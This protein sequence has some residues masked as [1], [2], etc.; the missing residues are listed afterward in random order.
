VGAGGGP[1]SP[2]VWGG[3]G[4][5]SSLVGGG[6][7][8]CS[9]WVGGGGEPSSSPLV[10]G[11]G[12]GGSSSP[13]VGGGDGP[14]STLVC[15]LSSLRAVAALCRRC[16]VSSRPSLSLSC[17]HL[18]VVL[19]RWIG[20]GELTVRC[21]ENGQRRTT[22]ESSFVVWL[23]RRCRRR[24]TWMSCQNEEGGLGWTDSPIADGDDVV[25]R[26]RQ[27]TPHRRRGVPWAWLM[28]V[29]TWIRLLTWR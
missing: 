8:P 2:L 25:R 12:A 7:G 17:R 3:G 24:G 15:V 23:P 14:S 22:M 13:L 29:V 28:M 6:V 26:H 27:T 5:C 20:P 11:A 9:P 18:L 4:P 1:S 10:G 19:V 21:V 16:V